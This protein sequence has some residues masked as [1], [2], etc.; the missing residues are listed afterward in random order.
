MTNRRWEKD[1]GK[2]RRRQA[3]AAKKL[4]L[5]GTLCAWFTLASGVLSCTL[6]RGDQKKEERSQK[7][8]KEA[9]RPGCSGRTV[10]P[11]QAASVRTFVFEL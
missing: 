11:D 1:W 4:C 7:G 3:Q 5:E 10:E 8:G 9:P 6:R 2:T